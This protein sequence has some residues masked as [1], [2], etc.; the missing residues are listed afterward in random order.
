MKL[1]VSGVARAEVARIADYIAHDSPRAALRMTAQLRER[2][3]EIKERPYANALLAGF[4]HRQIRRKVHGNYLIVYRIT[5]DR[6]E[7]V[8]V[9]HGAMDYEVILGKDG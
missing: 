8:H 4:V 9:L 2:F 7:V 6:I 5:D 1:V 3:R